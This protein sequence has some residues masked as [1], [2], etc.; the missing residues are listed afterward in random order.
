[1][2]SRK[3]EQ[4]GSE[5]PERDQEYDDN[6]KSYDYISPPSERS[7]QRVGVLQ[8]NYCEE[9]DRRFPDGGKCPECPK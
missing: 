3:G 2:S 7:Y 4:Q 1:M 9:H 8:F 5:Q 6:R